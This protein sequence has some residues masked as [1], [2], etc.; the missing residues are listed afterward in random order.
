MQKKLRNLI[1]KIVIGSWSFSGNLGK[2]N[3][4]DSH[5][6]ITYS[7]ENNIKYFD[8]APVYGDGKVDKLLSGYKKHIKVN[9]KCGYNLKGSKKTFK[10]SDIEATLDK[11]LKLFDKINILYLHN[12]RQE[13]KDWDK[14]INYLQE[15]KKRKLINY[16]GISLAR[17]YYFNKDILNEFDFIQE[18]INL[19]RLNNLNYLNKLKCKVVARSPLA[20]GLLSNNFNSETKFSKIDYRYSWCKGERFKN[21]LKQ[22][23]ELKKIYGKNKNISEFAQLYLLQNKNIDL[24]NFGV[25]NMKQV[26]FILNI[27]KKKK[28]STKIT[29]DL[30]RL[31]QNNYNVLNKEVY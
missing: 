14:I 7:I 26:K 4:K 16:T 31:I 27:R 18:D 20:T 23:N 2:T 25:K 29:K 17:G 5:E 15:L 30:F 3:T 6:A 24:I 11:S 9:T 10:K 12:P 1:K 21:I 13:I 28:I 22:V 19:L 8:T